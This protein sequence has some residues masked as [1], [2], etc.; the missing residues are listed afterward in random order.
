V[1]SLE[2]ISTA[3]VPLRRKMKFWNDTV[4]EL[5]L[6]RTFAEAADARTFAGIVRKKDLE[7][8]RLVE[9]SGGTSFVTRVAHPDRRAPF[10]IQLSLSGEVDYRLNGAVQRLSPGDFLI[11]DMAS[12]TELELPGPTRMLSLCIPRDALRRCIACP[13]AIAS[14]AVSGQRGAAA[15][16]SRYLRDFW[17][18]VGAGLDVG[19]AVRFAHIAMEL[20]ASAY[21]A[22]PE[23]RA[24]QTGQPVQQHL[25][26][27][28]YIEGQL[29][30]PDLTPTTIARALD[31]SQSYLHRLFGSQPES[32][33]RYILRRRLEE[34]HRTLSDPLL[35]NR[36]VSSVALEHGFNSLS[37]FCRAF[38]ARY[39][40]TPTDVRRTAR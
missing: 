29:A 31:M 10:A 8:F 39:G 15:L 20:V 11:Y 26:I 4:S 34:C 36:G 1:S 32:I 40:S 37:Y 30:N 19:S 17:A 23:A 25:R 6:G 13:E 3:S 9:I 38:R 27:R 33:A 5:M 7:G 12:G 35:R 28:S 18:T 24:T 22:M 14:I 2:T 16:V 21:A